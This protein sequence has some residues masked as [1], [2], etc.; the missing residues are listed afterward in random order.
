MLHFISCFLL[1]IGIVSSTTISTP[2]YSTTDLSI[3]NLTEYYNLY[4]LHYRDS[5]ID[6]GVVQNCHILCLMDNKCQNMIVVASQVN[7]LV[8][9]CHGLKSCRY[10]IVQS[11]G[12]MTSLN[13]SCSAEKACTHGSVDVMDMDQMDISCKCMYISLMNSIRMAFE[14]VI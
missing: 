6:C 10:F 9:Q 4:D 1:W 11:P 7:N 14:H 5:T 8:I 2:T 13:L 3:F 12:P